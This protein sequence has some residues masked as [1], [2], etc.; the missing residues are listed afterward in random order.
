MDIK[1]NLPATIDVDAEL[2]RLAKRYRAAN[3]LG[4]N[5]LNLIGGSAENLLDRLPKALR[6]NLERATLSALQQAM[7][8]AHSSRSVVPDQ[9]SWLNQA[10]SAA[11]GAAGGAGGLPTA[12]AELP[13]TTTLLL[14][15]IQGVAVEH[16]FDPGAE[17]VQF[18]CVQVF[19]AAGPLSG[20]D[21]ADLG[22]LAAR[23]TLTGKAVQAV[24]H[25]VAPKLAIVMGQKLAAQT[26]PVLGA[27]AGAATNYA[28]TS[29]YQEI[30]HVHFGLRKLAIDA[31][32]PHAE[33]L[34]GLEARM[35]RTPVK[36]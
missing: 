30:A 32:V 7:K 25:R 5:V 22:F 9:K 14:R 16:G 3:G 21:G 27:V 17:N 13:V 11:M 31:D 34:K 6:T 8:A 12:L 23:M 24:V 1:T 15:V 20:D 4:M 26:V 33:L 28:Y 36:T 2:D 35:A 10:V 18:D 29:Y 19:A